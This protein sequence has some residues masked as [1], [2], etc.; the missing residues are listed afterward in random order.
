M[1][2]LF[3]CTF[4]PGGVAGILERNGVPLPSVSTVI[5]GH[6]H[7]DHIGNL[8]PFTARTSVVVGPGSL[9]GSELA[10]ELDVPSYV[11]KE[12]SL[13]TLTHH[14]DLWKTVGCF[15]GVDYFGDG[16]LWILDTPGVRR[17]PVHRP[18]PLLD[19]FDLS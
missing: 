5:F 8:A 18:D 9:T 4:A 19:R 3:S 11:V 2:A 1:G 12:R 14:G 16:S 15:K 10:D 13:R 6:T 7:F 17:I